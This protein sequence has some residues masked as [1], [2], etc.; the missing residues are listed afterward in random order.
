MGIIVLLLVDL[1]SLYIPQFVGEIVDGLTGGYLTNVMPQLI[2][3]FA[4][5]LTM[6]LGR[7]GWRYFIVGASRGIEYRLRDDM[8]AHLETLS[9]RF[10]NSH[11]TGDLMAHFTNDLQALRQAAGMAVVTAFD[12]VIMTVM[13]LVKMVLY[14]NFRLTLFAFVPLTT[15]AVA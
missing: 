3:I 12:A 8:F 7:F 6:T 15:V 10:Y 14:V 2:G 11:K 9:A 5:G 13:V 4:A 1:A